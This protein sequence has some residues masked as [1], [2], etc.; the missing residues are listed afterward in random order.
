MKKSFGVKPYLYPMPVL[1]IATYD[2]AG[3]V[4]VMNMAWGGICDNNKVALNITESHKTAAN[5]KA[6]G[7][8]TI[9]IADVEHLTEADYFGIVSGN[10]VANKFEQSGLHANKSENVDAPVIEEFPVVLE[11]KVVEIHKEPGSFRVVGEIVN[12]LV[13][14]KVLDAEGKVNPTKVN[15]FA[16]DPFQN[17]YYRI[18]EKV[19]QAWESGKK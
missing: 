8:F 19:G 13:D 6:K 9:S 10:K 12:T 17:G 2:E 5:I 11:C 16:F 7:A 4:D 1:M 15:A 3:V 18:G 14:E